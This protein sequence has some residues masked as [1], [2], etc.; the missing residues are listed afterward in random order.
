MHHRVA[1]VID[2]IHVGFIRQ[3]QIDHR[4]VALNNSQVKRR[5]AILV[6]R[7]Q[8]LWSCDGDAGSRH[9]FTCLHVLRGTIV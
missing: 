4:Q 6:G 9:E 8:Q 5:K 3:Q 7:L 2:R 1:L